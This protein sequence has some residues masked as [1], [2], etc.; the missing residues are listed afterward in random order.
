M[1]RAPRGGPRWEAVVELMRVLQ[2]RFG[3]QLQDAD[4]R[5]LSS[6]VWTLQELDIFPGEE[7][8]RAL[9]REFAARLAREGAGIPRRPVSFIIF[10]RFCLLSSE[11]V[12]AASWCSFLNCVQLHVVR[13]GA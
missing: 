8:L 10:L 1:A 5:A 11:G 12:R 7:V 9:E 3:D 6:A 4:P 2:R 13:A